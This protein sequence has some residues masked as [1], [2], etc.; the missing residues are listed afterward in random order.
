MRLLQAVWRGREEEVKKLLAAGCIIDERESQGR[1]ALHCAAEKGQKVI[2]QLLLDKGANYNAKTDVAC[3]GDGIKTSYHDKLTP[4]DLAVRG[5]YD[6]I[7]QLLLD[8][9]ADV[10]LK[11]N[12]AYKKALQ[13]RGGLR[14][15]ARPSQTTGADTSLHFAVEFGNAAIV[16]QLLDKGAHLE[17]KTKCGYTPLHRAVCEQ[18]EPGATRTTLQQLAVVQLLL[19]KG[20]DIHARARGKTPEE[21]ASAF[22]NQEVPN[23]NP[24]N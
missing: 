3:F 9:G 6:E 14:R 11:A 8:K 15:P 7:V 4:L 20:A 16:Q 2:V 22:G 18:I 1:S 23:P 17:V 19:D 12:D 24:K 5:G 21:L 13:N 10:N